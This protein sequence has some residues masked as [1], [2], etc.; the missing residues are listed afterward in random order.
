MCVTMEEILDGILEMWVLG[1]V[2][3]QLAMWHGKSH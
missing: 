1:L 2:L 3:L